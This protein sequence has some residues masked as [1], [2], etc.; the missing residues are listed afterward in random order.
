[1]LMAKSSHDIDWL[2]H[3]VGQPIARVTSFGD[4]RHFRPENAPAGAAAR[5]VDCPL[6]TTCPYSTT[7]LY[8]GLLDAG[9]T[10]WPIDTVVDTPTPEALEVALREGPYGRC[11]YGGGNDV[12]D[13]QVVSM[14]FADGTSGVF[15]M[16]GFNAGGHRR[17]RIFGTLGELVT[18]GET[19]EVYE[20]G[21]D[22]PEVLHAATQG[23]ATAGGGHGGGDAGLMRAF[24]DAVATG[25]ASGIHS[26]ASASLSSHLAVFAAE[27]ARRR[28]T[29]ETVAAPVAV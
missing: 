8:R 5:C 14:E 19:I 2:Q 16:T 13:H 7:R 22:A 24:V 20:F 6:Q 11:V 15:T 26:G 1:M 23:D 25:D 9:E 29:V 18:D 4:L 27:R 28:G 10:G 21:A 12:V 3:V 17:T